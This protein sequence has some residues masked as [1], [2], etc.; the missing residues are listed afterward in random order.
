MPAMTGPISLWAVAA[1]VLRVALL[2]VLSGVAL[3]GAGAQRAEADIMISDSGDGMEITV[4]VS[5]EKHRAIIGALARHFDLKVSGEIDDGEAITARVRSDLSSILSRLF[6]ERSV[7]IVYGA[8]GPEE[9]V[10]INDQAGATAQPTVRDAAAS[11]APLP[12]KRVD[13]ADMPVKPSAMPAPSSMPK[14]VVVS[15][16]GVNQMRPLLPQIAMRDRS[17]GEEGTAPPPGD[18][19]EDAAALNRRSAEMLGSLVQALKA[20]C[21]SGN[22]C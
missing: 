21:P 6:G 15:G 5:N 16:F 1:F 11:E 4:D 14:T 3:L 12:A 8:N 17:E 2:P 22:K 9:L 20:L 7:M 13:T 10:I 18:S 19:G